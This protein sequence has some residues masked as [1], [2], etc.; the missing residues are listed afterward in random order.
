[1]AEEQ[2]LDGRR[3]GQRRGGVVGDKLFPG[4]KRGLVREGCWKTGEEAGDSEGSEGGLQR[5]QASEDRRG[6]EG[7]DNVGFQQKKIRLLSCEIVRPAPA[8]GLLDPLECRTLPKP[9]PLRAS[10]SLV[11]RA[12]YPL[13]SPQMR[14][15]S[16]GSTLLPSQKTLKLFCLPPL[17][18]HAATSART[19]RSTLPS[20]PVYRSSG[21]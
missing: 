2:V 1:M 11:S 16:D 10:A 3:G 8:Q 9:P 20:S 7:R 17:S 21:Q 13:P 6:E 14:L 5:A 19:A 12:C 18:R 4:G 15:T